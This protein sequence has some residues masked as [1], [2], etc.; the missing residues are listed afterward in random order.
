MSH[1]CFLVYSVLNILALFFALDI[2]V[3]KILW[4]LSA[5]FIVAKRESRV[6]KDSWR[7]TYLAFLF[8]VSIGQT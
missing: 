6:F 8:T 3:F 4:I 5:S 7:K 1:H 2:I